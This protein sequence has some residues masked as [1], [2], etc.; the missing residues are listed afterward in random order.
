[1]REGCV[2]ERKREREIWLGAAG[3]ILEFK[4]VSGQVVPFESDMPCL[5][6]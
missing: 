3:S 5:L 6:V 1:V 2:R 4:A